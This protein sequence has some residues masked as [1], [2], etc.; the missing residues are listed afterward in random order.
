MSLTLRPATETDVS[1]MLD[2]YFSAFA[3][4]PF[5]ER[6]F[7]DTSPQVREYW[8]AWI[9]KSLINPHAYVFV[10]VD[11]GHS[12]AR[13]DM[14]KVI[15]WVRW[16]S[17]ASQTVADDTTGQTNTALTPINKSNYPKDG[18]PE[19]AA[20]FF[21]TMRDA[22]LD[23]MGMKP[24]W[25]LSMIATRKEYQGRGAARLMMQ[26]GVDRADDDGFEAYVNSSPEGRPVYE[27]FGF[28]EVKNFTF[29]G[30]ILTQ[31]FM[32]RDAFIRGQ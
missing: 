20:M 31:S 28:K 22:H 14:D 11:S 15:A 3:G 7:P 23:I 6:C 13:A 12:V 29:M 1:A 4:T 21:G 2:V 5:S 19:F 8:S 25:F 26:W 18:D 16:V 30:G 9:K 27:K 24:H 17:F 32:K 10:V